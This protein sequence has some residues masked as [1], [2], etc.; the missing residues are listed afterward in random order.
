[1]KDLCICFVIAST[2]VFGVCYIIQVK[3]KEAEATLSTW[4]ILVVGCS[5]SFGTYWVAKNHDIESGIMNTVDVFYVFMVMVG[6]FFWGDRKKMKSHEKWYLAAVVCIVAYAFGTGDMYKS[7][8]FTQ[9]LIAFAYIPMFHRMLKEKKKKD[10]YFG[11]IPAAGN[12]L[13]ALYPALCDGNDL[14]VAYAIRAFI[15]AT[16]TS[17]MMAYYQLRARRSKCEASTVRREVRNDQ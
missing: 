3:R 4:I 11:W 1:V 12:A 16:I 10:S 7:N 14:A 15:F 2:L 13:V 17:A 8:W 5:L 6:V 9:A